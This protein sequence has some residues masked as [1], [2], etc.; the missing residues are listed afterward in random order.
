DGQPVTQADND[1]LHHRLLRRGFSH[2]QA[3]III[4]LWSIALSAFS[5]TL[6]VNPSA[7]KYF[8]IM[9]LLFLSYIFGEYVGFF[10]RFNNGKH[11]FNRGKDKTK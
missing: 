10:D 2:R 5:L 8:I 3:V 1:H 11:T 4:Y 7:Y 9:F 6:R